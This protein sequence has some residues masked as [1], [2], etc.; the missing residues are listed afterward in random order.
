VFGRVTY[1]AAFLVVAV[2]AAVD[3]EVA[4]VLIYD[5]ASVVTNVTSHPITK[6]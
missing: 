3:T 6:H 2:S 1:L 4:D 5:S